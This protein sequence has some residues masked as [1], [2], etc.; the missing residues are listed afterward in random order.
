M[1]RWLTSIRVRLGLG[2]SLGVTLGLFGLLAFAYLLAREQTL[3]NAEG[4]TLERQQVI[5]RGLAT[6][7]QAVATRGQELA[8][9]LREVKPNR[10]QLLEFMK[11]MVLYDPNVSNVFV[12]F[13]RNNPISDEPRFGVNVAYGV[14]GIHVTDFNVTGYEFWT[15]PWYIRTVVDGD[16]WWSEPYFNDAAGGLDV[17]TYDL[18]YVDDDGQRIGMTSLSLSLDRIIELGA[19]LG[20]G[21]GGSG[22]RYAL[23]DGN[24]RLV[25]V[26]DPALERAYTV[27]QAA[28]RSGS[29]ALAWLAAQ[30]PEGERPLS[31]RLAVAKYGGESV[32]QQRIPGTSWRVATVV[33]HEQLLQPLYTTVRRVAGAALLLVL[34]APPL[35]LVLAG[36]LTRPLQQLAVA[37]ERIDAGALDQPVPLPRWQDE[38]TRLARAVDGLRIKLKDS[39][40]RGRAAA[41][42]QQRLQSELDIAHQLQRSMLPDDRLFFG[43]RLECEIAGELLPAQWVAGDFYGFLAPAPG[44]CVFY[45]GDVSGRGV[46]AALVMARLSALL[47][48]LIRQGGT[49]GQVLARIAEQWAQDGEHGHTVDLLLGRLDLDDGRLLLA[50][51]RHAPPVLL[52]ADGNQA[53]P[54]LQPG[55]ALGTGEGG[56]WPV[57]EGQLQHGERLIAYSNGLPERCNGDGQPYGGERVQIAALRAAERPPRQLAHALIEDSHRYAGN[58]EPADDITVLVLAAR[59]RDLH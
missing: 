46:S 13:D 55:P 10:A 52:R 45:V 39:L 1:P 43:P 15:K 26:W 17:V 34:L 49:P 42:V 47:P 20:I 25:A 54:E 33:F 4:A 19:E 24:Q 44:I 9:Q 28:A 8:I 48:G 51:A 11:S 29:P 35:L 30:Q 18:P 40:A 6:T 22:T 27:Q 57:W 21:R 36:W 56:Q 5:A 41:D 2:M 14:Q 23:I 58:C 32:L 50:S 3:R 53:L 7:F 37:A 12:A 31:T 16:S 59:Q 38:V